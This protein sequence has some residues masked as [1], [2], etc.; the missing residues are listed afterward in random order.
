MLTLLFYITV[1]VVVVFVVLVVLAVVTVVGV[2]VGVA[3]AVVDVW[4]CSSFVRSQ[5]ATC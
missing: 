1:R 3:V 4:C 5:G 2:V